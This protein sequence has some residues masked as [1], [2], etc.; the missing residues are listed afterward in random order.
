MV[1]VVLKVYLRRELT[2]SEC[3]FFRFLTILSG[4]PK[5]SLSL[6]FA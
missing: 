2:F 4:D 5:S 6:E 3:W 1:S